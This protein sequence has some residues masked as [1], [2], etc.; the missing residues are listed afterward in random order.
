MSSVLIESAFPKLR[1]TGYRVVS[2]RDNR[3]NCI[4]WAAGDN[5]TWWEPDRAKGLYWPPG[6]V[7]TISL[8]ALVEAFET[9]GYEPCEDGAV[10]TDFEKIAIYARE[11]GKPTHAARQ[12]ENGRWTSKLGPMEDI[13]HSLEGL[14]GSDYG[15]VARYLR[16]PRAVRSGR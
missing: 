13:E 5:A 6:V 4:A 10:E 7:R 2:P 12:L 14:T 8:S 3:Y 1:R 15:R 9:L 16:R 11:S